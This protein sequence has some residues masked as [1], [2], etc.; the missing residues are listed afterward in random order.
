[1]LQRNNFCQTDY[2]F[3][4][5]TIQATWRSVDISP[6]ML[7]LHTVKASGQHHAPAT[8][9]LGKSASS[10]HWHGG[11]VDPGAGIS[12]PSKRKICAPA[13]NQTLVVIL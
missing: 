2:V 7:N 11:W 3:Q 13:E 9:F 5:L 8:L 12:I 4:L 1:M 6:R 10:I